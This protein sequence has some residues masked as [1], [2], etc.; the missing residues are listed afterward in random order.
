MSAWFELPDACDAVQER[1]LAALREHTR[2]WPPSVKPM[3]SGA[4]LIDGLLIT[5]VDVS[6]DDEHSVVATFR[7]DFD[8]SSVYADRVESERVD[9]GTVAGLGAAGSP[10]SC[11]AEAARWYLGQLGRP[12]E[13][14]E[15]FENGERVHVR[16]RFAGE[17]GWLGWSDRAN[18]P[19][20]GLGA[21]DRVVDLR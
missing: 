21:A 16:W 14:H 9:E 7:A 8:G 19:R 20:N 17:S 11:A 4:F 15:W 18:E 5:Y 3:D 1:F 2:D 6:D 10:E 12:V 13:R